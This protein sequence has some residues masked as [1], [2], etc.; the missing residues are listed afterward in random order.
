MTETFIWKP[1]RVSPG[2]QSS[3]R[4]KSAKFGGGYEQRAP[5]GINNESS[6]WQLSFVGD[7]EK[8]TAIRDFIRRHQGAKSFAWTPP[9]E[10]SPMLFACKTYTPPTPYETRYQLT[11]TFEQVFSP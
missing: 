2:G 3:F 5:D 11:A 8:I 10:T 7:R 4:V 9:L 1:L 6:T